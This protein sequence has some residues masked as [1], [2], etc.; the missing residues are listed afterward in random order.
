MCTND[1]N[2]V[3]HT[4]FLIRIKVCMHVPILGVE[5][6]RVHSNPHTYTDVWVQLYNL[7]YT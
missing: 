5:P 4:P 3:K 7:L 1:K 2:E 6:E